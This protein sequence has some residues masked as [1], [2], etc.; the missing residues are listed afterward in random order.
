MLRN[1]VKP[2]KRSFAKKLR[3]LPTT[4]ERKLWQHLR[5]KQLGIKFR[6]QSILRGY[7]ADFYAAKVRLVVEVDGE[8]HRNRETYDKIRNQALAN[9]GIRTLRFT[10]HDVVN[11]TACVIAQIQNVVQKRISSGIKPFHGPIP[12]QKK[13]AWLSTRFTKSRITASTRYHQDSD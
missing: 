10:N 5:R 2:E 7:I 8:S 6:R 3:S 9:I 1:T 13:Q 12:E 4:A 11:E